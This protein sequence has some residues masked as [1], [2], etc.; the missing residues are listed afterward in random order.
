VDILPSKQLTLREIPLTTSTGWLAKEYEEH[1][2]T[3]SAKHSPVTYLKALVS[4]Q[5]P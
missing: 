4:F 5:L 1:Q 2:I 3:K